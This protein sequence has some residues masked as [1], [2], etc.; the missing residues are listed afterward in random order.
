MKG[1]EGKIG[2]VC[3]V[4]FFLASLAITE[5]AGAAAK[6]TFK[7]G[8]SSPGLLEWWDTGGLVAV[9]LS[10]LVKERTNGQVEVKPY[11]GNQFGGDEAMYKLLR[12]GSL[13]MAIIHFLPTWDKR[14]NT[15]GVPYLMTVG[16][17]LSVCTEVIAL[18]LR[19]S[20]I[21]SLSMALNS[22]P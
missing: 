10:E 11:W 22:W 2:C 7:F 17:R 14:F 12:A 13:E 4:L 8:T 3:L 19:E 16:M 21:F 18:V 9:K 1:L 6:W 20:M 15:W 5:N